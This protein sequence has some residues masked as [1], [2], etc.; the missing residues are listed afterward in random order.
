MQSLF[1]LPDITSI[2]ILAIQE[3]WRNTEIYTTYHPLKDH[4]HLDYQSHHQTRV[5]FSINKATALST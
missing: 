3:P 1:L 4:F 5:C 2:D